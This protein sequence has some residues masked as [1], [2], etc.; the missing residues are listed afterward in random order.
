MGGPVD[1]GVPRPPRRP[2]PSPSRAHGAPPRLPS[3]CTSIQ[4]DSRLVRRGSPRCPLM[5]RA[6][7][8][9]GARKGDLFRLR[10]TRLSRAGVRAFHTTIAH[11]P[12]I[13]RTRGLAAPALTTASVC[14]GTQD[15]CGAGIP[16]AH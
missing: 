6:F 1:L 2:T 9:A 5:R 13:T 15:R 10:D 4:R 7:V 8:A 14:S 12:P 11:A 16:D 3:D